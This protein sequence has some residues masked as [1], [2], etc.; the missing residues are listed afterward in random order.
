[1][2]KTVSVV[3]LQGTAV[4]SAGAEESFKIKNRENGKASRNIFYENS[5]AEPYI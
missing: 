5:T 2:K 4:I 3:V 1:M